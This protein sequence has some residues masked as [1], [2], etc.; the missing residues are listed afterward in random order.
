MHPDIFP[1]GYPFTPFPARRPS[2]GLSAEDEFM[3]IH[4]GRGSR[5][6]YAIV[7]WIEAGFGAAWRMPAA[8]A[9]RAGRIGASG[10]GQP[11]SPSTAGTA[12]GVDRKQDGG[13][14]P[15]SIK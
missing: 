4:G 14:D 7:L 15:P 5:A 8:M 6:V 11:A 1:K 3:R 12:H 10:T 9:M 2:G 13:A